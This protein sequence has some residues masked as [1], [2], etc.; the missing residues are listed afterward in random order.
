MSRIDRV[1]NAHPSLDPE[2]VRTVLCF[3][4]QHEWSLPDADGDDV[5]ETLDLITESL[6]AGKAEEVSKFLSRVLAD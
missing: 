1:L 2:M 6:A 5:E 3:Y 4:Y